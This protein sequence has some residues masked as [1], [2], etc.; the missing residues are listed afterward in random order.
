VR[1]AI[2]PFPTH[3]SRCPRCVDVRLP[4]QPVLW[5][6]DDRLLGAVVQRCHRRDAHRSDQ[7]RHL[8]RRRNSRPRRRNSSCA[9][10]SS[11]IRLLVLGRKRSGS[12]RCVAASSVE[13]KNPVLAGNPGR[14][15]ITLDTLVPQRP[16]KLREPFS[17]SATNLHIFTSFAPAMNSKA[18]GDT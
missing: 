2:A 8:P 15:F 13:G 7:A 12:A 16:Q 3:G 6:R 5:Q 4:H 11:T 14:A 18:F 1:A 17:G 10:P 9:L